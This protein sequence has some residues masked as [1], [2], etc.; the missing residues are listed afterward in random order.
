[1]Y[2]LLA[3]DMRR[4]ADAQARH[5]F[6]DL[7]DMPATVEVTSAGVQAHLHRC[8]HLPIIIAS[9]RLNKPVPVPWWKNVPLILTA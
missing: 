6:R 8:A 3:R 1:L 5:I 7:I 4:Y 2:R 9:G